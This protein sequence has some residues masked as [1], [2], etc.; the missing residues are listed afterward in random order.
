MTRVI[1]VWDIT[2]MDWWW[3]NSCHGG[4]PLQFGKQ[5]VQTINQTSRLWVFYANLRYSMFCFYQFWDDKQSFHLRRASATNE[6]KMHSVQ[7]SVK[8]WEIDSTFFSLEKWLRHRWW[9]LQKLSLFFF[10]FESWQLVHRLNCSFNKSVEMGFLSLQRQIKIS[11]YNGNGN[12]HTIN[13][14]EAK[15]W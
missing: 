11:I 10:T 8:A 1:K 3:S 2:I 14:S 13:Q 12:G 7:S 15:R 9:K 6:T 4:R 5:I